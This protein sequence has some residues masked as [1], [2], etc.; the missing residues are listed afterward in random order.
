MTIKEIEKKI[1]EQE[2]VLQELKEELKKVK[3]GKI[4]DDVED[5]PLT[6]TATDYTPITDSISAVWY[7]DR[8]LDIYTTDIGSDYIDSVLWNEN[9]AKNR[10]MFPNK[11]FAEMYRKKCKYIT[12]MLHFKYLYDRNYIPN[13]KDAGEDKYYVYFDH[14]DEIYRYGIENIIDCNMIYFSAE[15]I[16]KKCAEWLNYIYGKG[17]RSNE[18]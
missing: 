5:I 8:F 1:A 17:N 13:M 11:E 18:S 2:N 3:E 9:E 7:V 16:A 14:D 15:E 10:T 6:L 12:D 4:P